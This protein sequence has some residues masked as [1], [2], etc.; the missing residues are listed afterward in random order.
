[1]SLASNQS[2]PYGIAVDTNSVYR[3]N[4]IGGEVMKVAKP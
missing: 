2:G 3:T 1:M 4:V